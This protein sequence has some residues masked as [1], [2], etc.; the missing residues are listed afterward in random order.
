MI[1]LDSP[2]WKNLKHAYGSAADIPAL[3]KQLDTYQH[4]DA[5]RAEP[6]FSIWSALAHQGDVYS[7]SFAAVPHIVQIL[8]SAPTEAPYQFF[9]FPTWVEICR[10]RRCLAVQEDLASDYFQALDMLASLVCA[11]S[12]REWSSDFL[13]VALSALAVSK[14]FALVAEAVQELNDETAERFLSQIVWEVG[15]RTPEG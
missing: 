1:S 9:Q 14:G 2:Q 5:I 8:A 7:A 15:S 11:A 4:S 12:K 10:Q 6:W 13:R 3:L